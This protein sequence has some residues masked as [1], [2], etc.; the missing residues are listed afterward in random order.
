[1]SFFRGPQSPREEPYS[2]NPLSPPQRN[3]NPNRWSAS[4]AGMSDVRGALQRRF[5]TNT[6]PTLSPIGQQRRQAAGDVQMVSQVHSLLVD[7]QR[8]ASKQVLRCG[9]YTKVICEEQA[10]TYFGDRGHLPRALATAQTLLFGQLCY[11]GHIEM[12]LANLVNARDRQCADFH[13]LAKCSQSNRAG[14]SILP[15]DEY[16]LIGSSDLT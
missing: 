15:F 6:V 14:K 1:M 3:A 8:A 7:W 16:D 2:S 10:G 4:M 11:D 13:M 5:T 9:S 12:A